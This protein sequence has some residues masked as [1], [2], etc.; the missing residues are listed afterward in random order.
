MKKQA[1]IV[2]ACALAA[3]AA[4]GGLENVEHNFMKDEVKGFRLLGQQEV[5][6]ALAT[7]VAG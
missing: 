2:L 1:S 6:D 4:L 3:E 5:D 7:V